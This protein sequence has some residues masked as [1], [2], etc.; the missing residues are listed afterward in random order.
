MNRAEE[1]A[2]WMRSA[3]ALG[4]RGLSTTG[5]NPA[6]GCVIVRDG[7]VVGRGWTQP[8]GRPHAEA[9]AL[10]QAGEQARGGTA[11]VTLEPCAHVS[12]RGPCCADSLIAAG[13]AR[14][15]VSLADPD[16]RTD[17]Q[18][19][20]RLRG[21][22]VAVD[23]DVASEV[24][25]EA[26]GGFLTRV[27]LGRPRV[28]LKL[29]TSL[30]GRIAT[31]S[32]DSQW[33]TGPA[34]RARVQAL[35]A[36]HDAILVGGGTARADR[37]ALTVRDRA[38]PRQPVRVIATRGGV[39]DL[40]DGGDIWLPRDLGVPGNVDGVDLAALM[41][42]LGARGITRVLCE[43]GGI[44]AA[45]LLRAGLVDV[46]EVH[47]AGVML[48]SD[49]L[50][51]LGPLGLGQLSLAPRFALQRMCTAGGDVLSVWQPR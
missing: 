41:Q 7:R 37:P 40:P 50:P 1:D 35:R 47:A 24:A 19:I 46:L 32:G 34:A 10:R 2:R 15:V 29:A 30:D 3:V 36:S 39:A 38:V 27:A 4:R 14:V 5:A 23:T 8:G 18:G 48:G 51:G 20:S 9:M 6:V 43:G 49:G 45:G 11:Y 13:V 12:E 17:G 42:A 28:T 31:A 25:R 33:I 16:P 26:L 44:L 22:G 21:A